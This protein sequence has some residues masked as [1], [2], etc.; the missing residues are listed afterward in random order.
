MLADQ[1]NNI[2]YGDWSSELVNEFKMYCQHMKAK[3][4]GRWG[5]PRQL[6]DNKNHFDQQRTQFGES[7]LISHSAKV[8]M[9][10]NVEIN[11][12]WYK[13][14]QESNNKN[15]VQTTE[16]P[17]LIE[18]YYKKH[19]KAAV[20][21]TNSDLFKS[22]VVL[23]RE[24]QDKLLE[25]KLELNTKNPT[26]STA[27]LFDFIFGFAKNRAG[28]KPQRRIEKIKAFHSK[29]SDYNRNKGEMRKMFTNYLNH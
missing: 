13:N 24:Q 20:L 19:L 9:N 22:L 14:K 15:T 2:N 25:L 8:R 11:V 17:N 1:L 10:G 27:F 29:L 16:P 4:K 5:N 7:D 3:R 26:L 23:Y 28:T 6:I 18:D 21:R 12:Q